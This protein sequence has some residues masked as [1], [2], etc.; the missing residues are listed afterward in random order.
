MT[1]LLII[2]WSLKTFEIDYSVS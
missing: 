2:Q 1:T